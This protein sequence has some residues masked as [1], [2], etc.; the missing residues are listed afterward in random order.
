MINHGIPN[1][2]VIMSNPR[3]NCL[4]MDTDNKQVSNIHATINKLYDEKK[5]ESGLKGLFS[6]C[7]LIT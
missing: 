2:N 7:L 3:N 4:D 5:R 1:I 6:F